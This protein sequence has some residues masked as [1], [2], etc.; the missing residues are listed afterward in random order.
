MYVRTLLSTQRPVEIPNCLLT[1]A[2]PVGPILR[3]PVIA[4]HI[5]EC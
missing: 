4:V 1:E 2:G 3:V 5:H